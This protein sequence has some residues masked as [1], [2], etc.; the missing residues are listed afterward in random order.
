MSQG[1]CEAAS[2]REE[3]Q[4][5]KSGVVHNTHA[6]LAR[7]RQQQVHRYVSRRERCL[8]NGCGTGGPGYHIVE[9]LH[10]RVQLPPLHSRLVG[11]RAGSAAAGLA[12][13]E[14]PPSAA[15]PDW[16]LEQAQAPGWH[17][18]A[19]APPPQQAR[20]VAAQQEAARP[21]PPPPA[22]LAPVSKSMVRLLGMGGKSIVGFCAMGR[23]EGERQGSRMST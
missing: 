12:Q 3:G 15:R 17:V 10:G 19:P 21:L 6:G 9:L 18:Q 7:P 2:I 22:D 16:P 8:N 4:E 23:G 14:G 1:V 20:A 13:H 5:K 11:W